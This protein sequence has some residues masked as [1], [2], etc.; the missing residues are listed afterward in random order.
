MSEIEMTTI[1]ANGT[2]NVDSVPGAVSTGYQSQNTIAEA[3]RNGIDTIAVSFVSFNELTDTGIALIEIGG[4]IDESGVLFTVKDEIEVEIVYGWN[5]FRLKSEVDITLRSVEIITPE[6]FALA[7]WEPSKNGWY[8]EGK[9]VLSSAVFVDELETFSIQKLSSNAQMLGNQIKIQNIADK[10]MLLSYNDIDFLNVMSGSAER[11]I[12]GVYVDFAEYYKGME[13]LQ[14]TYLYYGYVPS[15]GLNKQV[16]KKHVLTG[17][18][19]LVWLSGDTTLVTGVACDITS[20]QFAVSVISAPG[21]P[22]PI[23]PSILVFNNENF[24]TQINSFTIPDTSVSGIAIHKENLYSIS[25]ISLKLR[26]HSGISSAISKVYDIG[27]EYDDIT[28]V[29]DYMLLSRTYAISLHTSVCDVYT[30]IEGE[31]FYIRTLNLSSEHTKI[32]YTDLGY[33]FTV[34]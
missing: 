1:N 30:E 15:G 6:Q 34:G 16:R 31:L 28:F 25:P 19:T 13:Q 10:R 8:H 11:E 21:V 17:V 18:E 24:T 2:A 12:T 32:A 20:N 7:S 22:V 23:A 26:R 4:S 27:Y 29:G 3:V 14:G 33:L 9:R 5:Y